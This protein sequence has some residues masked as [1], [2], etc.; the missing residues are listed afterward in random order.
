MKRE[1]PGFRGEAGR[2]TRRGV[3][4]APGRHSLVI[5]QITPD[6]GVT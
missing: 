4:A 6:F 5:A 2:E 1:T 3:L